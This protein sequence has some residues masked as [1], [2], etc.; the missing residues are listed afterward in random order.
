MEAITFKGQ[1]CLS[2]DAVWSTL[3]TMFNS[4]LDWDTDVSWVFSG[5]LVR[6]EHPWL[7]F[8]LAEMSEV[9][10][11]CSGR[12]APGPDNLTWTH[13]KCLMAREEVAALFLWIINACFRV[14][15]WPK[16]LK[17]SKTVV[18]S[19]PGKLSVT[20]FLSYDTYALTLL[21]I[22]FD[23]S[24]TD[25]IT[26]TNYAYCILWNTAYSYLLVY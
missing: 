10:A 23:T 18:I 9:L 11:Q 20:I 1:P 2:S 4:A 3:H 12:S 16:E 26:K 17:E 22:S 8:S 13:L 25:I 15:V 5:L 24:M 7:A 14:G 19:K 6:D 21:L